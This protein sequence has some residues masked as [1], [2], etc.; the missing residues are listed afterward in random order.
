LVAFVA[1]RCRAA[2]FGFFFLDDFWVMRDAAR[3]S[4]HSPT[5]L[6][7]FFRLSHVGFVMYRPLTTVTYFWVLRHL[8][9]YDSSA[10]HAFQVLVFAGSTLLAFDIGRRLTDST[11]AGLAV[12]IAFAIAPGQMVAAHW[13]AAFTVTG[14]AFAMLLL[15]WLWLVLS[16]WPRVI[17][18]T[19]MQAIGLLC[20]EHAVV[21]P[22]LLVILALL[23]P[24]RESR[25]EA[26]RGI[27]PGAVLVAGYLIAKVWYLSHTTR[28]APGYALTLDPTQWFL[29]VGRYLAHAVNAIALLDLS[30]ADL[31]WIGVAL[32][33]A[34]LVAAWRVLRGADQWALLATGLAVFGVALAPVLGLRAHLYPQYVALAALGPAL[35]I[36]GICRLATRHWRVLSLVCAFAL[37]GVESISG[38]RAWAHDP[39]YH[40]IAKPPN[41]R[42]WLQAAQRTAEV[43]DPATEILIPRDKGTAYLFAFAQVQTFFPGLPR[44]IRLY[45]PRR[46]PA[47]HR[48]VFVLAGP[49]ESLDASRP[50][51]GC[52]PRWDWLRRAAAPGGD[53][54]AGW[55]RR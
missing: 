38:G 4:I 13:L 39:I 2:V 27:A 42:L 29:H 36:V 11:A 28:R 51:P 26:V 17:A 53:V 15:L 31:T 22:L 24:R 46:P 19:V 8:F 25:R 43:V 14:T 23:S 55:R 32:A 50:V 33:A 6:F 49:R 45:D 30:E 48:G 37:L 18:C 35:A 41:A 16:G 52:E 12:G 9:G 5:D 20:S 40:L 1:V 3:I 10:Y 21:G 34:G 54:V 47:M 7:D 44:N